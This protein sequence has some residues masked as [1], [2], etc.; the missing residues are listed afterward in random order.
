VCLRETH[1]GVAADDVKENE[2]HGPTVT[3]RPP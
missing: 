2:S 3:P 1:H